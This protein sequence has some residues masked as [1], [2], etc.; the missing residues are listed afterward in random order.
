L[1]IRAPRPCVN[2][3]ND[4][5]NQG[6]S[7]KLSIRRSDAIGGWNRSLNGCQRKLP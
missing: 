4:R 6:A 2:G 1:T 5:R 3:W 7:S